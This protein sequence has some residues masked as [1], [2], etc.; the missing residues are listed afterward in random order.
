[1]SA[2]KSEKTDILGIITFGIFLIIV[3]IIYTMTPNLLDSIREFF[4]DLEPQ[5]LVSNIYIPTPKS[6]HPVLYTALY[7]FCSA[8]AVLHIP[9][10]AGRFILKESVNRKAET[11]SSIFFWFGAAR[12]FNLLISTD[13]SWITFLGYLIS[14]IG[15]SIVIRCLIIL[16]AYSIRRT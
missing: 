10:L 13:I 14:L 11:A 12:M 1:M 2:E 9:I 15:V 3:S 5:Q 6:D 4:F 7:Q 8:F 16:I